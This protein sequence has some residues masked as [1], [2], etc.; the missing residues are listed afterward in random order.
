ME[1]AQ[2]RQ[3]PRRRPRGQAG[4]LQPRHIGLQQRRIAARA[5]WPAARRGKRGKI[6]EIGLIGQQCVARRAALGGQHFQERLDV[7]IQASPQRPWN[8]SFGSTFST[9][10]DVGLGG[11]DPSNTTA[12][13]RITSPAATTIRNMRIIV[14]SPTPSLAWPV[15]RMGMC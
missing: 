8:L 9:G 3:P 5:A 1:L 12:A 4:T 7:P 11:Y 6:V 10:C 13:P 14:C 2:R 15:Q